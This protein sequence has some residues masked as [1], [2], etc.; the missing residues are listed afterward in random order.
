M[1]N[2]NKAS[3]KQ[4]MDEILASAKKL[5]PFNSRVYVFKREGFARV[6]AEPYLNGDAKTIKVLVKM[7]SGASYP[8][9]VR[10]DEIETESRVSRC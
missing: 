4:V 5:Y 7:E 10:H 9:E 8:F 3:D 2:K 6:I 1:A